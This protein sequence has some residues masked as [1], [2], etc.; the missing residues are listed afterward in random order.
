MT[1]INMLEAKT[2]LSKWV[3]KLEDREEDV[4]I[5]A[6]SGKPV[7]QLTLIP[8]PVQKKRIG[9]A[10]GKFTIPDDFDRWDAEITELFG[11]K[12]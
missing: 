11:D 1:Q 7:A 8:K 10:K 12:L 5:L 2:D 9:A 6:R 4:V 3:K